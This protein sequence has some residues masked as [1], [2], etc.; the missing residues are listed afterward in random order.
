MKEE[1]LSCT[2]LMSKQRLRDQ[3]GVTE[4]RRIWTVPWEVRN[5]KSWFCSVPSNERKRLIAW[6]SACFTLNCD[7]R[8]IW[9][10]TAE[11]DDRHGGMYFCPLAASDTNVRGS[12]RRLSAGKS[13]WATNVRRFL[14][15]LTM[16]L[17]FCLWLL[18]P[19]ECKH[20]FACSFD[21]QWNW[22]ASCQVELAG[23]YCF[24]GN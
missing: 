2:W 8:Q 7:F 22:L 18:C 13:P 4:L 6:F 15:K 9:G 14:F 17:C 12:Q 23:S 3:L 20:T 19:N 11:T 16:L 1:V 5:R 24:L 21:S 10:S